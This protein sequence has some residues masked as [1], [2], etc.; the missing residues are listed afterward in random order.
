MPRELLEKGA[1]VN[2]D[3]RKLEELFGKDEDFVL[4][5]VQL[6]T[7]VKAGT[8]VPEAVC[9]LLRGD[10]RFSLLLH[11]GTERSFYGVLI[12]FASDGVRHPGVD[13]HGRTPLILAAMWGDRQAMEILLNISPQSPIRDL[14][15][16]NA[17]YSTFI[18]IPESLEFKTTLHLAAEKG[19]TEILQILLSRGADVRAMAESGATTIHHAAENDHLEVVT[20]LI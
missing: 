6:I 13:C 10:C 18:N 20:L 8:L 19:F 14:Q 15:E 7:K 16:G 3:A 12:C 11:E 4:N 17:A 9:R 5:A 1:L 2:E